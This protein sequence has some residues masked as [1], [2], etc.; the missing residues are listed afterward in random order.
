MTH[1]SSNVRQTTCRI[2]DLMD[3]GV[4]DPRAVADMCLNWL[5]EADVH[6]MARRNDLPLNE[7]Y[8]DDND[9]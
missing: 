5:S 3:E 7:D 1:R 2:M 8:E 9:D 6:E 4:L